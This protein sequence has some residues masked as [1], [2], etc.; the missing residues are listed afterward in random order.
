MI[1]RALLLSDGGDIEPDHLPE[2]L[3]VWPDPAPVVVDELREAPDDRWSAEQRAERARIVA[4]LEAE[5]G[6]QTRTA[7]RLGMPRLVL[8]RRL[9]FFKIPRPQKRTARSDRSGDTS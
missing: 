8:V 1:E 9:E 7:E 3:R 6:N 4:G 2:T 5:A